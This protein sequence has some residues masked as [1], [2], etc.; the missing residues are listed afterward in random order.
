MILEI[1]SIN[2]IRNKKLLFKNLSL[3]LLKSQILILKGSNGIGKSSLLEMI[4][5]V[6]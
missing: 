6:M 2:L 3:K 4:V 1:K 5:G